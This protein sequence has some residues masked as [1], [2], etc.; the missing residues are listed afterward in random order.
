MRIKVKYLD[1]GDHLLGEFSQ[2]LVHAAF[3]FTRLNWKGKGDPL[4]LRAYH[5]LDRL[6]VGELEAVDAFENVPQERLHLGWVPRL[7]DN[8]KDFLV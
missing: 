8:L 7:T 4:P 5:G 2:P 6:Q 3:R 1:G